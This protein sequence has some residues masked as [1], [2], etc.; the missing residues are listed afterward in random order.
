MADF[1]MQHYLWIKS[2]HVIS[3]IA[4]MAGMLYLP[5][6]YVYHAGAKEGSEESETFKVMENR[7]LRYIMNPAMIA[8]WLFGTMMI[9]ANPDLFSMGWMH[10][11]FTA[12]ILMTVIHMIY[13]RWRRKFAVDD[14]LHTGKFY[15]IW[16][17]IPT[18][19]LIIIVIMAI[20]KPF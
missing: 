13:A 7:L 20:A 1:L 16:N 17:E 15:K 9:T 12:V 5:R 3:V 18:I 19:L 14:N 4:W 6:L 11:K 2:F 10:V 8:T